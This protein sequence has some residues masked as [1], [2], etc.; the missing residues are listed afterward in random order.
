MISKLNF[1]IIETHDDKTLG[2]LDTSIYNPRIIIQDPL[3]EITTPGFKIPSR[4]RV[5][6]KSLNIFN[7]NNLGLTKASCEENMIILPDG[8]YKI[9]YSI[10]PNDK[11]Y[12]EKYFLKTSR[13]ES[14]VNQAFLN[15]DYNN[16]GI[17]DLKNI[18]EIDL[19]INGAIAAANNQDSKLSS[20]LYKK[21]SQLLN[22][23][24][25]KCNC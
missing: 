13:I 23:F 7:S 19:Y 5:E 24:L 15:L 14:R 20:D 1:T 11:L 10:C 3:I 9:R 12:I 16:P 22:S 6:P 8:L 25:K 2:F 21:A 4:P 17:E 18:E